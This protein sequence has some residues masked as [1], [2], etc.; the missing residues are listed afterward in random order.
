[1]RRYVRE[2]GLSLFF[3]AIFAITLVGQS[4]AGRNKYNAVKAEHG[5]SPVSWWSYVTSTDFGGSVMENWQSEF[6]QFLA[7]YPGNDLVHP[8]GLER[9][10]GPR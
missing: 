10:E 2:N 8:E 9:V 5:G 4:F 7:L 3:L 6:L 1:M